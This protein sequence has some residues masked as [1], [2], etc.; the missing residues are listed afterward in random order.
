MKYV[1]VEHLVSLGACPEGAKKLIEHI[2]ND[3]RILVNYE[4]VRRVIDGY[5]PWLRAL[6]HG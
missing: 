3:E 5:Y 6:S 2:G 4:N 1:T